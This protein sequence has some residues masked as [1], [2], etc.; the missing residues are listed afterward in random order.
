MSRAG[1]SD[2]VLMVGLT[3]GVE[4]MVKIEGSGL[5]GFELPWQPKRHCC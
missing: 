5:G 3:V 1:V 4:V 2:G